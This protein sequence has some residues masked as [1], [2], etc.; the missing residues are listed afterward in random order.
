MKKK[1]LL[2]EL[3]R[4]E[5]GTYAD[6][7]YRNALLYSDELAFKCGNKSVTFLDFNKRVNRLICALQGLGIP[8]GAVLSILSWNCLEYTEIYG[9]AMKGGFIASPFNARLQEDELEYLINYSE[10]H[11][12]FI[13]PE[14]GTVARPDRNRGGLP[15]RHKLWLQC[16]RRKTRVRHPDRV[17]PLGLRLLFAARP[18][19]AHEHARYPQRFRCRRPRLHWRR[20]QGPGPR[21]V[22]PAA[23]DPQG[24]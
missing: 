7:I 16:S 17:F 24:V 6:I 14:F 15:R 20:R 9:A 4:Y 12:L 23:P 13:G 3:S 10:T 11:T 18:H 19:D 1:L 21:I 2:K 22:D 8:K 5:I